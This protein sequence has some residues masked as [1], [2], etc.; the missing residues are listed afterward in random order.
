[1]IH[2][3]ALDDHS[4]VLTGLQ[5]YFSQHDRIRLAAVFSDVSAATQ[6]L[7][8]QPVD[9]LLLDL[10][11]GS[12]DGLQLCKQYRK[13]FPALKIV[14]L[15]GV[16]QGQVIKT[17]IKN[18][19]NA[20][21]LKQGDPSE[22]SHAIECVQAGQDYLPTELAKLAIN[23]AHNAQYLPQLSRREREIL[24]LIVQEQ[25]TKEIAEKLFI[26]IDTVETHRAN[27]IQKLQVK[28]VAGLVRV[29]LEKGLCN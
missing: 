10:H 13:Q 19:A 29:A 17:A 6:Y 14:I 7:E 11:L 21:L 25:T 3:I 2:T 4:L 28:N 20:Y 5:S 15:S 18:G 22:L 12:S 16:E 1:M 9:V 8:Q 27:L 26:S 24:T 23:P